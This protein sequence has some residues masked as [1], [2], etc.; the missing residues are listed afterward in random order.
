MTTSGED[1]REAFGITILGAQHPDIR[2]LKRHHQSRIHGNKLWSASY[3][4]MDYLQ[5]NPPPLHSHILDVGC[6]WG[7]AGIHCARNYSAEVVAADADAEV[8]PFLQL[9]ADYNGVEIETR[10]SRFEELSIEQLAGFDWLIGADI[11]FWDE[12]AEPVFELIARACDAGVGK[13]VIADPER[14]PFFEM[15]E[16]CVEAFYGEIE[17]RVIEHPRHCSGALLIIENL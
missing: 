9:H 2:R 10:Q 4:L 15:A 13:I 3:L 11:C 7:L 1:R 16:Q 6:G 12:L 17:A 5:Q 14:P 8:F